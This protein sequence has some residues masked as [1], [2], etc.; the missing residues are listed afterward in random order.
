MVG[1]GVNVRAC[2]HHKKR[3]GH[4]YSHF[5]LLVLPYSSFLW[6]CPGF[7]VSSPSQALGITYFF[8]LQVQSRTALPSGGGG[9]LAQISAME[10]LYPLLEGEVP[11]TECWE[12][13]PFAGSFCRCQTE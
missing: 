4:T 11:T 8:T 6:V 9:Y 13:F 5:I 3:R 2:P 12:A 1:P 10:F 7:V